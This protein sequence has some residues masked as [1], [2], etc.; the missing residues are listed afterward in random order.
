MYN[1]IK[2]SQEEE[3]MGITQ[4]KSYVKLGKLQPHDVDKLFFGPFAESNYF[5][6]FNL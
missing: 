6:L 5:N 1:F 3:Q 2:K 4:Y